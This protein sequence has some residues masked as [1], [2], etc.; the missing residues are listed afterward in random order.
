MEKRG[1][2]KVA[3]KINDAE[4]HHLTRLSRPTIKTEEKEVNCLILSRR[5]RELREITVSN[6]VA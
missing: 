3:N 5:R 6:L 1:Q 2:K 4:Q